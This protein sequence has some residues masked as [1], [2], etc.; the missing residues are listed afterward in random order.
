LGSAE[1]W[2]FPL[3]LS[4]K[5]QEN[6][7]GFELIGTLQL[8]ACADVNLSSTNMHT[9]REKTEA[10]AIVRRLISKKH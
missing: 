3:T 10:Q 6:Q 1:L 5:V 2:E 7:E 9:I 4:V 8:V